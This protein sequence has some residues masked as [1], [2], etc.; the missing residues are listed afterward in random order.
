MAGYRAVVVGCGTIAPR[1]IKSWQAHPTVE[2]VA[3]ADI[4]ETAASTR[5]RE[6]HIPKIYLDYR[7][8]LDKEKP[9]L[10]S[11]CT[12]MIVHAEIVIAAAEAGVKGI[13]SEK[14]LAGSLEEVDWMLDAVKRS[15]C[16]AAV[17]HQHRFNPT[18]V[19][20]RRLLAEGAIGAPVLL[21]RRTGGGLLNN[22]CHAID[23]ARYLLGDPAPVWAL[24]QTARCT[25]R[26]E[27]HDPI[28]D[29]CGG[30]VAFSGGTRVVLESDLP[31][32]E[33]PGAGAAIYGTEGTLVTGRNSLRL[34][35]GAT[36]GWNEI[37]VEA[38]D[39][40]FQQASE[41]I[42]WI[43]GRVET[44]RNAMDGN[45]ATLEILM[46]L[47]ASAQ[48]RNQVTFPLASGP[49]PLRQMIEDA[50]LP[51]TVPGK[52]DIRIKDV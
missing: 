5:A 27:R 34:L 50:T 16:K 8:M 9:D 10:I 40:G 28:E 45:R 37:E 38:A 44:H 25:D 41:L 17:G 18:V 46:S 20:A 49:S 35:S 7:E 24:G 43:E 22:G 29:L 42:D 21:H 13:M 39:V 1:H 36:G 19:E 6:F 47:Y 23:T 51:V 15:G 4:D 11:V 12:W 3:V 31:E 33:P 2:V 48:T 32:P 52:Y 26:Y 30:I 14:P